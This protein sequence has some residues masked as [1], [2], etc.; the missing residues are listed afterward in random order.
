[1]SKEPGIQR[2]VLDKS[3]HQSVQGAVRNIYD[4]LYHLKERTDTNSTAI[5]GM[6]KD[7]KSKTDPTE[8]SGVYTPVLFNEVNIDSSAAYPAQWMR[9]AD[10]KVITVSGY[11]DVNP[12]A[13]AN[14]ELGISVPVKTN[15]QFIYQLAGTAAAT[16]VASECAG[17]QGDT[18]NNR[19]RMK[20]VTVS[21][22]NHA[23]Y[24]SFTYLVN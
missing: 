6:G 8:P 1:M 5:A 7:E 19:A 20:W 4:N 21:S 13:A 18:G 10:G 23:M 22:A 2:P 9:S 3:V 12:T 15:L 11:V 24:Y 17:I 16:D 14:T